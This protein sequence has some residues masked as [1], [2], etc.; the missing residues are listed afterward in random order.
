MSLKLYKS[1]TWWYAVLHVDGQRKTFNLDVKVCGKRPPNL[2]VKGDAAFE[3]SRT[4][5]MRAHDSLKKV[6]ED[7]RQRLRMVDRLRSASNLSSMQV[8]RLPDFVVKKLREKGR[9]EKYVNECRAAVYRFSVALPVK[10]VERINAS[11]LRDWW[12]GLEGSARTKNKYRAVLRMLFSEL[13]RD[14][15]LDRSP[16]EGLRPVPGNTQ[17]REPFTD[18][19][20]HRL[21]EGGGDLAPLILV[22]LTTALRLSDCAKLDWRNVDLKSGWIS[23]KTAKTGAVVD[24]PISP[25]L[26]PYLQHPKVSGP[27]F[28]DLAA[29]RADSLTKRFTRLRNSLGIEGRKDFHSFRVTWITNALSAGIQM[30]MVRRVSGHSSLDVV[31]RHYFRPGRRQLSAALA[32]L[33]MYDRK[34]SVRE[35]I[36]GRLASAS[37]EDLQRV[38]EVLSGSL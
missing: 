27:V 34:V 21:I 10:S 23:V 17:H 8:E 26:R 22:G 25:L 35:E 13:V 30:E 31:L 29:A 3:A 38:L 7:D 33:P 19:E 37:D 4:T 12:N 18:E 9:S 20:V 11:M 24:M 1:S 28:P 16:A 5:A 32:A 15:Y 6:M 2:R 14:G 36:I